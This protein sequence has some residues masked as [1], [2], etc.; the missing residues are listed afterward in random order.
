[1]KISK[2]QIIKSILEINY[3]LALMIELAKGNCRRSHRRF[4]NKTK[5]GPN[6]KYNLI[7][8]HNMIGDLYARDDDLQQMMDADYSLLTVGDAFLVMSIFNLYASTL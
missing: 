5:F 8:I 3:K 4:C 6:M 2:S 7:V 1:M